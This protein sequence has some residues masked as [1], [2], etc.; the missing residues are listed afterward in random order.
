MGASS[1]VGLAIAR[2]FLECSVAGVIAVFRRAGIREEVSAC[3]VELGSKQCR[4][5]RRAGNPSAQLDRVMNSNLKALCWT[6]HHVIP[7][8]IK[9]HAGLILMS[10]SV[11]G[12]EEA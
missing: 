12:D 7:V 9:Q 3:Q 10:G 2:A 5:Q 11:S 1:G 4:H 8:I 6:A